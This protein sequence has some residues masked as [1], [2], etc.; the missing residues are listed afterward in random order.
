MDTLEGGLGNDVLDG[1][2]GVDTL[3][4]GPGNDSYFVDNSSDVVS[5]TTGGSTG[6]TDTVY[7]SLTYTLPNNVENLILLN[8]GNANDNFNATGNTLNNKLIG[9]SGNNILLGLAGNDILNGKGGNDTLNGGAGQDTLTGGAGADNF[10]FQFSQSTLAAPDRITDFVIGTDKIDLLT[11]AGAATAAPT[12]FS[13][14]ANSNLATLA[15][16]VNQVFTDANGATTGNQA[17]GVN[18]AALVTVTTA[19]IAGT[20]LV[21]NDNVAGFQSASDSF[22]NI[23]GFSGSL[24]GLGAITPSSFFA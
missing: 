9:N 21:I 22:V 5:E 12:A 24:P 17:L 7:A 20:Y 6:G 15:S 18:Q 11:Q 10:I 3:E 14:A 16:V 1:G 23:T 4:G 8:T 13:R 2:A 19:G